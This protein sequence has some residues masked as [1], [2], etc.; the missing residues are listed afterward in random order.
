[1]LGGYLILRSRYVSRLI[2][3]I[4][5]HWLVG[6]QLYRALGVISL[7]LYGTGNLPGLF[8][9]PAG[10]GDVAV[11]LLA[12]VVAHRYRRNP[13]VN[14]GLVRRWNIFGIIDLAVAVSMGF[15][16]SPS[17]FQAF[18]FAEPNRLI[19]AFP[20]V[21]IPVFLVP[22]SILLHLASF[23]SLR[24]AN[25]PTGTTNA[26]GPCGRGEEAASIQ[27]RPAT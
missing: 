27:R 9:L 12:P 3:I 10:I 8:A 15:L 14:A 24:D 19:G 13:S 1:V 16:T 11:G 26:S 25:P 22:L 2:G 4:P 7:V 5:P 17:P 18:A 23:K 20:L 21:L 6:I